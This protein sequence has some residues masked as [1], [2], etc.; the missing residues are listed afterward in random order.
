MLDTSFFAN[1]VFF[2]LAVLS[3]IFT[4]AYFIGRIVNRNKSERI[5]SILTNVLGLAVGER[6]AL[7]AKGD[8][9]ADFAGAIAGPVEKVE[10]KLT[11][12]PRHIL[13]FLPFAKLLEKGDKLLLALHLRNPKERGDFHIIEEKF[14]AS[15]IPKIK[16]RHELNITTM[17]W[18]DK[19]FRIYYRNEQARDKIIK[20]ISAQKSFCTVLH[21][22]F[23]AQQKKSFIFFLITKEA[24]L[25]NLA[26]VYD[27]LSS[28]VGPTDS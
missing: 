8:L 2:F 1:G 18:G 27:W 28:T 4:V 20:F 15:G 22:A 14:A 17:N 26:P 3:A 10:A 21:V 16:G 12:L 23:D 7:G 6:G 19:K 9:Y 24:D 13:P 11:L 5:W 25:Q